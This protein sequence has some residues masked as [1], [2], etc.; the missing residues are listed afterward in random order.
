M[1]YVQMTLTAPLTLFHSMNFALTCGVTLETTT[2][3]CANN[4]TQ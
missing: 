3:L 2:L 1:N 4:Q